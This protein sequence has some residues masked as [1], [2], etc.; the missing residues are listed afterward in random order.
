MPLN[1][2]NLLD[3]P[4]S[5]IRDTTT[6]IDVQYDENLVIKDFSLADFSFRQL[7]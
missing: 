4:L 5:F 6:H 2:T 7:P 1:K 3:F